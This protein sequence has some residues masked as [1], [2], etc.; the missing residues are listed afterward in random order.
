[1]CSA[2]HVV[3]AGCHAIAM[4]L[5]CFLSVLVVLSEVKS[6]FS[7]VKAFCREVVE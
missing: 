7:F 6:R 3:G 2:V 1:M 4:V 5:V